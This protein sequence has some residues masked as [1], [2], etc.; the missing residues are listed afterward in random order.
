MPCTEQGANSTWVV[1]PPC[2]GVCEFARMISNRSSEL[3]WFLQTTRA[4]REF[5]RA[6]KGSAIQRSLE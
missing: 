4:E 2:S 5:M 3:G 1:S 6:L